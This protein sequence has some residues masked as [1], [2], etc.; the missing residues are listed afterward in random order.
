MRRQSDIEVIIVKLD[1]GLVLVQGSAFIRAGVMPFPG[2][3]TGDRHFHATLISRPGWE[4]RPELDKEGRKGADD[5]TRG[6]EVWDRGFE[7]LPCHQ[8]Q[9]CLI[10]G[11]QETTT[12]T[13]L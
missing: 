1:Q 10:E 4:V 6:S 12:G 3:K 11:N 7:S 2:S 9:G 5:L 8:A 13:S